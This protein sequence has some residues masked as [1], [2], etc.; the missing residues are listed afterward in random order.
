MDTWQF[1]ETCK[2]ESVT[3]SLAYHLAC[4]VS[5]CSSDH[6]LIT[7]RQERTTA[8]GDFSLLGSVML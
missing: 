8:T 1:W 7:Q 3:E 5:C 2:L 4:S 6:S